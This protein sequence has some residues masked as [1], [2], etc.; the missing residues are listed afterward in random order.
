MQTKVTDRQKTLDAAASCRERQYA[1]PH[2]YK[3]WGLRLMKRAGAKKA[4][5][6]LARKMAVLLC[7]IW[8]EE[9]HFAA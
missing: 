7:R 8:K 4:R 6:A 3:S 5:T 1:H 2:R 9:T